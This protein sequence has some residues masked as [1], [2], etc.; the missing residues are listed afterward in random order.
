MKSKQHTVSGVSEIK[1]QFERWCELH[2]LL[3]LLLC[4]DSLKQRL[5]RV[6]YTYEENGFILFLKNNKKIE[7]KLDFV[8]FEIWLDNIEID[9]FRCPSLNGQI[10]DADL[11]FHY[12]DNVEYNEVINVVNKVMECMKWF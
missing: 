5:D 11:D 9:T 6:E 12:I 8:G 2:H 10:V 4:L 3:D 7:L 1:S